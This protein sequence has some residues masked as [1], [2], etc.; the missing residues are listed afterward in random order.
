M[1]RNVISQWLQM[2]KQADI[3]TSAIVIEIT[4]GL[5]L[6]DQLLTQNM[7]KKIRDA[8]MQIALDD[9]GTGYSALAYLKKLHIDYLKIDQSFVRDMCTDENDRAIAETIALMAKRLGI[10]TIAEG[11]ESQEQQ[12][13]LSNVDCEYMQGY[14]YSPP[15]KQDNFFAQFL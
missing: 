7:L 4:E 6:D 14:L 9:F 12:N 3:P 10:T 8:G 11:V 1:N 13:M 5:L 15:I 2:I